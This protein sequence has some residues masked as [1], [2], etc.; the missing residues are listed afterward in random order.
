MNK[1]GVLEGIL[2]VV[3]DEGITIKELAKCMEITEKEV[4]TL[5]KDAQKNYESDE[6]GIR[7]SFIGDTFKFTTKKEHKK[8]YKKLLGSDELK[9][10]SIPALEVLAIIAY[11]QP[12]TRADVDILRGVSSNHLVRKLNAMGLIKVSGKSDLPGKPN[13]YSTTN[14]FLDYFGLA[15]IKD[16]PKIEFNFEEKREGDL[17][18]SIYKENE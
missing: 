1:L 8:Y 11:N 5:L 6:R 15:T 9:I 2:F 18:T 3:G 14:A 17:F 7:I 10:L 16:L 13:L 4:K 12:I